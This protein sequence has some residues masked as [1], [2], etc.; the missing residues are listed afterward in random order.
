ML[1]I[2]IKD[3]TINM[4]ELDTNSVDLI[5]T[6]PPYWDAI[7]YGY[8]NQLGKGLTYRHFF[9]LL[10]RNFLECMRIV[11]EDSFIA[12]VVGDLRKG[13]KNFNKNE[14]PK[15]YPFHSDIISFF[16]KMDFEFFQ[17]FI[18]KKPSVKKGKKGKIVYGSVGNGEL[19]GFAAPP[20]LYTDLSIEHVLVFRK[21]GNKQNRDFN[22]RI[23]DEY[24]RIPIEIA[25]EWMNPVWTIDSP[26]DQNHPATFPKEIASRLIKLYSV[27]SDTVLDP[28]CGTGT[29]LKEAFALKRNAI[30][31]ELNEEY[32]LNLSTELNLKRTDY[33]Y[34]N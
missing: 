21:P 7:D 24:T 27:R 9:L 2:F 12:I 26:R 8:P 15:I 4:S 11:K 19:K 3:S 30:G 18:W 10:E 16:I 14:R 22:F 17:H 32:L 5:I 23:S 33:G 1:K 28:F 34:S 25:K 13:G 31:F 6:S 20:L 29:L